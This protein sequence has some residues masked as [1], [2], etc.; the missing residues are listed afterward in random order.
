ME[1]E[2]CF[3]IVDKS[4]RK[5]VLDQTEQESDNVIAAIN[6]NII[7]LGKLLNS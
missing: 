5:I 1:S 3:V 2:N 7:L 6:C 4:N